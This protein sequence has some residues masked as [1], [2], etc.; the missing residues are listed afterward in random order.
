MNFFKFKNE[1]VNTF[2]TP[3]DYHSIMHYDGSLFSKNGLP[4]MVPKQ[5]WA[6]LIDTQVLTDIDVYEIRKLYN[7][8]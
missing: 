7:C 3:Y 6:T 1:E 5:P 8:I 4:T 2:G